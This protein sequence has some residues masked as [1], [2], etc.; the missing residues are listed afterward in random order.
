MPSRPRSSIYGSHYL[1]C[2][3]PL[4]IDECYNDDIEFRR[5]PSRRNPFFTS[6]EFSGEKHSNVLR[7]NSLQTVKTE[8]MPVVRHIS[9]P[10]ALNYSRT[11]KFGHLDVEHP[12]RFRQF[13]RRFS[14]KRASTQSDI[15][16][17]RQRLHR[18]V[19]GTG[20]IQ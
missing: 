8:R 16:R 14:S 20:S 12:G 1:T 7:V 11:D 5:R 6:V 3:M 10:T 19:S 18:V 15:I 4:P 2:D 17:D 13:L 9:S